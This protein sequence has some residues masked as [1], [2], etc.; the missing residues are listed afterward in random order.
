M[1]SMVYFL[2]FVPF[3]P[4]S[5][6]LLDTKGL[7][8][9]LLSVTALNAVGAAVRFVADF[10]PSPH[11]KLGLVFLGQTLC[12]IAQ[13]A[14]LSCPTLLAETWFAENQRVVANTVASLANPVGIA[15][16]TV[17]PPMLVS[18]ADGSD[19]RW[20]MLYFSLPS[21]AVMV[22]ILFVKD[23]PPTPPS[24]SAAQEHISFMVRICFVFVLCVLCCCCCVFSNLFCCDVVFCVLWLCVLWLRLCFVMYCV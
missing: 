12:A 9:S 2:A 24:A 20:M 23:K 13:P 5:T 8:F 19:M 1:L 17:L 7:R 16:G 3:G 18:S 6:W 14:I 4:A 22:L 15:I 11:G 21:F 10:V